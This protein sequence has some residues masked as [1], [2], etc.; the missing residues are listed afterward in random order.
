MRMHAKLSGKAVDERFWLP[1]SL[2]AGW[3]GIQLRHEMNEALP[4]CSSYRIAYL[5]RLR[6][7]GTVRPGTLILQS[8]VCPLT[9]LISDC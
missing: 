3:D 7:I 2:P 9:A 5:P 6:R 1:D 4:G 8:N